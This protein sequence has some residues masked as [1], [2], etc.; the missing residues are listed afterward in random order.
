MT[1]LKKHEAATGAPVTLTNTEAD[2]Y[3]L[4]DPSLTPEGGFEQM[5]MQTFR[6]NIYAAYE[7]ADVVAMVKA[8]FMRTSDRGEWI[9]TEVRKTLTKL[10]RRGLL[11]SR[12]DSRYGRLYELAY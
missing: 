3:R 11:R 8:A 4:T 10:V 6:I 2:A 1:D 12:R 9:D 7:A 5:I